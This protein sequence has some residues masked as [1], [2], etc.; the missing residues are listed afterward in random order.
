VRPQKLDGDQGRGGEDDREGPSRHRSRRQPTADRELHAAVGAEDQEDANGDPQG[1]AHRARDEELGT[2]GLYYH[3]NSLILVR[4]RFKKVSRIFLDEALLT[5][6]RVETLVDNHPDMAYPITGV[7][8][9]NALVFVATS[10][11]DRPRNDEQG[12]QHPDVL[13]HEIPLR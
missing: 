4:P 9:G 13:I 10:F 1:E 11:A 8:V 12:P 7:L 5:V 3:D 2:D 6:T